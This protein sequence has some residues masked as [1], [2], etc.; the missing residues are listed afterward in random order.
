M[1]NLVSDFDDSSDISRDQVVITRLERADVYYHI[2]FARA[3]E[4][5]APRFVYFCIRHVCAERK[6]NYRANFHAAPSQSAGG[7]AH[8]DRVYANRSESIAHSFF[9][10]LKYFVARCVGF[11]Q[12]VVNEASHLSR[13]LALCTGES[14]SHPALC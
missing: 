14:E 11:K 2:Q 7:L 6:P 9:A 5:R 13:G 8:P 12:G 3:V 10:H 4:D 1:A